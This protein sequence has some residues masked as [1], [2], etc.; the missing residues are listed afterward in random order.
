MKKNTK[1]LTLIELLIVVAIIAILVAIVFTLVNQARENSRKSVCLSN[2]KQLIAAFH[3]YMSDYNVVFEQIAAPN[4]FGL[5]SYVKN[6]DVLFCPKHNPAIENP[7]AGAGLTPDEFDAFP[8]SYTYYPVVM[9][10]NAVDEIDSY[11]RRK[12]SRLLS[13]EPNPAIFA[14]ILHGKYQLGYNDQE[15]IQ[16]IL[17][18]R[19]IVLRAL[20]DGS[21]KAVR[22]P[23]LCI[24]DEDGVSRVV[25]RSWVHIYANVT[26][27]ELDPTIPDGA[28]ECYPPD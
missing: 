4:W 22:A 19:G 5:N 3:M 23:N 20:L 17:S 1:G 15:R 24:R 14:C 13:L 26:D 10:E 12:H 16:V 25:G 8:T 9:F 18:T 2:L 6:K 27:R 21:A 28:F 11:L 7:Y